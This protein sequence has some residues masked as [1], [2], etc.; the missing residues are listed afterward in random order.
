MYEADSDTDNS[1]YRPL[2]SHFLWCLSNTS[3]NAGYLLLKPIKDGGYGFELI[4]L[5]EG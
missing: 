1:S 5:A 4:Q 3:N 2:W